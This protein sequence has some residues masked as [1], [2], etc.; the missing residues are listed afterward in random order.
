MDFDSVSELDDPIILKRFRSGTLQ[1][2][3]VHVILGTVTR[4]L[5]LRP[6]FSHFAP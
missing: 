5:E 3:A 6:R 4:A 1:H 2:V